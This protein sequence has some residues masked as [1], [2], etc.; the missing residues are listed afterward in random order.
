[1]I[2]KWILSPCYIIEQKVWTSMNRNF[3]WF[4][5]KKI[6][7]KSINKIDLSSEKIIIISG[8]QSNGLHFI[9]F[10]PRPTT[11]DRSISTLIQEP[12]RHVCYSP[13]KLMLLFLPSRDKVVFN[14]HILSCIAYNIAK[15]ILY[16]VRDVLNCLSY[17]YFFG[18]LLNTSKEGLPSQPH[19]SQN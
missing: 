8:I 15:W 7:C 19:N 13:K 12:S 4:L 10:E 14:S 11:T 1:M 17:S 9:L 2:N 6:Q 5:K 3:P 18:S 16:V